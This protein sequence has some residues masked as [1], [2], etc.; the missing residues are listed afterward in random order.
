MTGTAIACQ[1]RQAV[2]ATACAGQ[3]TFHETNHCALYFR[4]Q[5]SKTISPC[6]IHAVSCLIASICFSVQCERATNS[7]GSAC[8]LAAAIDTNVRI[9]PKSMGEGPSDY[10]Y[11]PIHADQ[12]MRV[13]KLKPAAS[14]ADPPTTS[15]FLRDINDTT[16]PKI[17]L[18]TYHGVT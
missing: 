3:C 13:L 7:F 10:R 18:S 1:L 15:L 17:Y 8:T 14:F 2:A 16:H 12:E 6:K 5:N 9:E 11:N 4:H